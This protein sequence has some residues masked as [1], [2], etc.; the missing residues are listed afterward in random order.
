M[1]QNT[2]I[3]WDEIE[4]GVENPH[5]IETLCARWI[6]PPFSV[7]DSRQSYWQKRKRLWL[8]LGIESELGRGETLTYGISPDGT[9]TKNGTKGWTDKGKQKVKRLDP[10]P[11]GSP[12]PAAD[13]S[14]RERGDGAGKPLAR[15]FGEDLM[16]GENAKFGK[17]QPVINS[18]FKRD[19]EAGGVESKSGTSIFDPVLCEITYQWFCPPG[20]H[21][22]DPFCGGSVRGVVA[23]I[24]GRQYV[25]IDLSKHQLVANRKQAQRICKNI[26]PAW[27]AGDAAD[28]KQICKGKQFDFILSCPPYG[29]LERYSDDP[30]DLST[31]SWTEFLDKYRSIIRDSVSLLKPNR[32]AA[33]VVGN[34]RSKKRGVMRDLVGHTVSA[35]EGCGAWF[36]NDAIF[37]NAIG[38]LPVRVGKQMIASRK[39]G[40]G[41]QNVLVFV[42]G[43]FRKA[44][45]A[46]GN[47]W[48][49]NGWPY[50]IKS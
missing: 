49:I 16:R 13:Y 23:S 25:G 50:T 46:I 15:C 8:K 32:F 40:K 17:S 26:K 18:L 38:S 31:M 1:E 3:A 24:T 34:F 47:D 45:E 30:R 22:L 42:K 41:H 21:V 14:K 39:L 4:T 7:L 35:F 27:I 37:V 6:V 44:V 20:G 11:G 43:D 9:D 36:Y 48:P 10:S 2:L 28:V 12:R 5:D 29:D 33:F 19:D